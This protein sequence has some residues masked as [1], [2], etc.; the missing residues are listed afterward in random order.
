METKAIARFVRISS[1]KARLVM[2]QV[3]GKNVGEARK[4]LMF[5]PQKAAQ[6]VK[7]VI[8]SAVANAE[9][10]NNADIDNLYIKRIYSDEGPTLKRWRPRAQ[11]RAGRIRKRTSHLTVILEEL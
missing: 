1:Q 7:R 9:H 3:R 4:I 11:G 2:N 6:L 10:N 5:A 8:D